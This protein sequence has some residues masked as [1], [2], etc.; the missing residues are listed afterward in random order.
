MIDQV[1]K[2]PGAISFITTKHFSVITNREQFAE[3]KKHKTVL[4]N[5]LSGLQNCYLNLKL[6]RW[7]S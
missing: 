6:S 4:K 2:S 7:N 1:H 3:N 5:L